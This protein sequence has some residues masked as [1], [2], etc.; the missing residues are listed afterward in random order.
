MNTCKETKMTLGSVIAFGLLACLLY[1]VGAGLRADIGILLIPLSQHSGVSYEDVSFC[2]AVMQLVFGLMQP[3]FG[4]I[5]GRRSNCFVLGL[6]VTMMLLSLAGHDA[7]P[8][9]YHAPSVPGHL[10]RLRSRGLGFRPHSHIGYVFC[11]TAL[12][13]DYF[14]DAQCLCRYGRI[15]LIAAAAI[16][17]RPRRR[18][19]STAFPDCAR[20]PAHPGRAHH[21]FPESETA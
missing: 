5:A 12:C 11:R 14:G 15:R 2:I 7:G 6:G 4:L 20:R 18:R 8:I 3:V 17:H 19:V 10:L 13:H 1:G 21:H 9:L 16:L